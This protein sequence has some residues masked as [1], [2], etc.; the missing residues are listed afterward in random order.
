MTIFYFPEHNLRF[1]RIPKNACS[2]VINSL[3]HAT[4][5]GQHPHQ[6]DHVFTEAVDGADEW[7]CFAILRDPYERIIS[8][9]L[10]K[11]TD[12]LPEELF[13]HELLDY[14]WRAQ[15]GR[16]RPHWRRSITFREF[17]THL[18]VFPDEQ[19]DPH[20]RSQSSFL[21]TVKPSI[22]LRMD[23]LAAQW[24][25][26][27]LF[28]NIELRS[29]APHATGSNLDVG[30][31]VIDASGEAF[32]GFKEICGGFPSHRQFYDPALVELVKTRFAEDYRL[33]QESAEKAEMAPLDDE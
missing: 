28:K 10:N 13:V 16:Q 5:Q 23:R 32:L 25:S 12:I 19:L 14:I 1:V 27:S 31:N 8:A 22:Y 21:Q 9:F 33:L 3:G 24:S 6:F 20:W 7:P 29:Y 18:C 17:V 15:R 30:A 26:N 11:F 4:V 2:T